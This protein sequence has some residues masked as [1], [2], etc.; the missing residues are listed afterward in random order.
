MDQKSQRPKPQGRNPLSLIEDIVSYV[1]GS[2]DQ[3]HQEHMNNI[4]AKL[5]KPDYRDLEGSSYEPN[6][7][8][9]E[10]A[11][12]DCRIEMLKILNEV[13]AV[14]R[15]PTLALQQDRDAGYMN[16]AVFR[17]LLPVAKEVEKKITKE[18]KPSPSA[19]SPPVPPKT[20]FYASDK[21]LNSEV[22]KWLKDQKPERTAGYRMTEYA[23]DHSDHIPPKFIH[24]FESISFGSV[25]SRIEVWNKEK[26]VAAL[27]VTYQHNNPTPQVLGS[28]PASTAS[29][30]FDVAPGERITAVNIS[31]G[32]ND[33]GNT[34]VVYG[35]TFSTDMLKT[36]YLGADPKKEAEV[37]VM[38]SRALEEGWS[39]KG[40]WAQTGDALDRVGL[41]W[42]KDEVPQTNGLH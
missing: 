25:V 40:F 17:K 24:M 8:G 16:P 10:K 1:E 15:D 37:E 9:L 34:K 22:L 26:H 4:R 21:P 27:R 11:R 13:E 42:G 19:A 41:F 6:F 2:G 18:I 36:Q 3:S 12:K 29:S 20:E 14:T 7:G 23:G 5:T 28:P 32:L 38:K 35:F 31:A 30:T 33:F 39:L